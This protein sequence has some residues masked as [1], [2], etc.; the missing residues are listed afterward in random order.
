L[1]NTKENIEHGTVSNL[2]G[3]IN[4]ASDVKCCVISD[5]YV[6]EDTNTIN[7]LRNAKYTI[8]SSSNCMSVAFN[9]FVMN[10][11]GICEFNSLKV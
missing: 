1:G 5:N 11:M 6:I 2:S 9:I 3:C 10:V 4:S 8:T 7:L